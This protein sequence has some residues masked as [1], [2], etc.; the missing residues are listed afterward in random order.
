MNISAV[1]NQRFGMMFP[2]PVYVNAVPDAVPA[3]V[4]K[5]RSAELG[6]RV[7]SF[8]RP[9]KMTDRFIRPEAIVTDS[10]IRILNPDGTEFKPLMKENKI[11]TLHLKGPG[12][13][14]HPKYTRR[15]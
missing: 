13:K 10:K 5:V 2:I 15:Y 8:L 1:N 9:V 14:N 12:R 6:S 7:N 3:I 11:D 4:Q